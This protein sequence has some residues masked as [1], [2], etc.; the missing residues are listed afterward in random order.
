M[1][2]QDGGFAILLDGRAVRSPA[3]TQVVVPTKALADAIAEEWDAQDDAINP[4]TMPVTRTCNSALD[5][6]AAQRAEIIDMLAEYGASDLTCYRADHP[7]GLVARQA[8][9]WDP[10][11]DWADTRFGARLTPVT[12]VMFAPQ[13]DS[14]LKLLHAEVAKFSDFELAAFHDLVGL[15]GSLI[16]ALAAVHKF[17][18]MDDLWMRSRVDETWQEEQWGEDEEATAMAAH[19]RSEF[20]HAGRM[21]A[22]LT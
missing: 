1:A 17:A 13:N 21:L 16:I 7:E 2:E 4:A 10:L 14:A 11:L 20:M 15:S 19:K 5:K 9:A 8:E 6:V 18:S 22:L 3:K 12:G